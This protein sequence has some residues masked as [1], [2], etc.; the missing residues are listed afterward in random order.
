M[1][2]FRGSSQLRDWNH[3]SYVSC[4]SRW[5]LYHKASLIQL[6]KNHLQCR[7][8]QFN[9]WVGKIPWRRDRLPTA[10]FLGFPCGSAG[11]ESACT[12]GELGL[13]PGLGST[14]GEK[15][16]SEWCDP[17]WLGPAEQVAAPRSLWPSRKKAH[18]E[19][20][21]PRNEWTEMRTFWT[22][23]SMKLGTRLHCSSMCR[24]GTEGGNFRE[25]DAKL[26][27]SCVYLLEPRLQLPTHPLCLSLN[28]VKIAATC[29][30]PGIVL[31]IF[32][33]ICPLIWGLLWGVN[34]NA[35]KGCSPASGW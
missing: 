31:S 9:S 8:P 15:V 5:V 10:V 24:E 12:V 1:P 6:V 27:A 19:Q 17:Q 2:S 23:S 18:W 30:M 20:N 32:G 35:G 26:A 16:G 25:K 13:I 28:P 11:K 22:V 34:E 3:I 33:E 4:I 21:C 14:V 29:H 7:R